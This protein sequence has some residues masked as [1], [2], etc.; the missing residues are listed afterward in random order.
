M[1]LLANGDEYAPKM[2]AF[3]NA[4]SQKS[5][6]FETSHIEY[7]RDLFL[8]F[9]GA[10]SSLGEKAFFRNGRFSKTLFEAAFVA[11]CIN[12]F[13][14]KKLVVGVIDADSFNALKN[15][16]VFVSYLMSG[17]SS[18]ENIKGRLNR[19]KDILRVNGAEENG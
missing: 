12:A 8:S 5:K 17:S 16:E 7:M 2:S 10:C 13:G 11:T 15:D 6:K 18:S 4:F 1:A 19:A 3:L 14:N 9:V